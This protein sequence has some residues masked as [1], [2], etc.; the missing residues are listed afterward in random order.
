MSDDIFFFDKDIY[1]FHFIYI[2]L[3]YCYTMPLFFLPAI[4]IDIGGFAR[5]VTVTD[6]LPLYIKEIFF[7]SFH[8]CFS[9]LH[10]S[11]RAT[12]DI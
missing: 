6:D 7:L 2:L 5:H 1:C 3:S 12:F 4:Y 10:F 8:Y 9:F 11:P